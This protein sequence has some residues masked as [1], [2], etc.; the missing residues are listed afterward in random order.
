MRFFWKAATDRSAAT[1]DG[2]PG[3]GVRLEV[4]EF[5]G[6]RALVADGVI[7]SVDV[8]KAD[9]PFGYWTAMLPSGTPHTAILLGLGAGTLAHL[10]NRRFPGI[11][12]TG[13]DNDPEVLA[14]AR[15]HFDLDLPNLKVIV[16]DAFDYVARC[17]RRFDFVA[18]DLFVGSAFER[19][20]LSP[21][22]LQRLDAI[23]SYEGEIAFNLYRDQHARTYLAEIR[24]VLQVSRVNRLRHNIIVHCGPAPLL[25]PRP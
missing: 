2:R 14:F 3:A 13:I 21:A 7:F 9:P 24:R 20:V 5:E 11:R 23:R 19:G 4:G 10:L 8:T 18:V 6:H 25:P 15:A 12:I 16:A 1:P 22:F 17:R